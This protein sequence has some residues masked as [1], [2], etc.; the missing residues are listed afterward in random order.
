MTEL[1]IRFLRRRLGGS[2]MPKTVLARLAVI[3]I[4]LELL[5]WLVVK[6]A[7]VGPDS[8]LN[9]LFAFTSFLLICVLLIL[10]VRWLRRRL[11]WRLRNRLIVTYVFIGVIPLVLL[12]GMAVLGGFL[13]AGQFSAFVVTSDLQGE[14]RKLQSANAT[15]ASEVAHQIRRGPGDRLPNRGQ[16]ALDDHYFSDR[17]VTAWY[18]GKYVI[19]QGGEQTLPLF[20]AENVRD[21]AV[22]VD[23]DQLFLRAVTRIDRDKDPANQITVVSSVPLTPSKLLATAADL[24]VISLYGT[25]DRSSANNVDQSKNVKLK[26][27]GNVVYPDLRLSA[28][29]MPTPINR[30]DFEIPFGTIMNVT[31]WGSGKTTQLIISIRTRPSLLYGRLF[32]SVGDFA[33]FI[34]KLLWGVAVVF[35]IIELIALIIG[36]RLTRTMTKSVASL[37]D[38]TQHI[39]AADFR[40][41]IKVTSEDQLAALETSFNSMTASLEQLIAEQKEKQRIESELAIAQEVQALL[42]PRDITEVES[43]EV[44]GICKPARTVSGDYYDFLPV[45][46]DR[47]GIAVGDISGKGISAALLMATVHAFVRAYTLVESI[48]ALATPAAVGAASNRPERASIDVGREGGDLPPGTLLSMLN[49][50]L[51]RS[52]PT[53]KYATMFLGFYDEAT[54]RFNYSNAGHLPPFLIGT[55]GSVQKLETGGLVVGLFGDVTYPDDS[56][57]MR[58]GDI[59]VAYSDGITEPENE[60]GEFGEDR[61]VSLIQ[62]NRHLP[63]ARISDIII[64]AVVDWIGGNEQPDDITLVLA[65]AR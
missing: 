2:L 29:E 20:P 37:Y 11:M 59:F 54:R 45:G 57:D 32:R 48:P 6:I 43:L 38:A 8:S 61:L 63:L 35:A 3:L 30:L 17:H 27:D 9:I 23:E 21:H 34:V 26:I 58:A 40:H 55:D 13:F 31:D 14:L 65:R 18:R 25:R 42:F 50:Q 15:I 24:G 5:E 46:P 41:R 16:L 49:S 22:V 33:G 56:I 53:E 64:A 51:Y 44:H 60:F 19:L 12:T 52:T 7:R 4:V 10:G 62:E 47:L 36:I 39:N 1:P 28:G